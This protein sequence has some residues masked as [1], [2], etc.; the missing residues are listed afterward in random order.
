MQRMRRAGDARHTV[1]KASC[2]RQRAAAEK[3]RVQTQVFR[4]TQL[5]PGKGQ[6]ESRTFA[7]VECHGAS[8]ILHPVGDAALRGAA[9]PHLHG[10]TQGKKLVV[11]IGQRKALAIAVRNNRRFSGLLAR[12]STG[13]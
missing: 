7:L 1:F 11:L 6:V 9:V 2:A 10:L 5:H 13:S 4:H 12:L 3:T 8:D